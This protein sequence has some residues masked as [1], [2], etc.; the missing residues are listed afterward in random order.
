MNTYTFLESYQ[1]GNYRA[2]LYKFAEKICYELFLLDGT[3]YGERVSQPKEISGSYTT[4]LENLK[5]M[6]NKKVEAIIDSQIN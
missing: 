2:D 4:N 1:I 3:L 6:I 5:L